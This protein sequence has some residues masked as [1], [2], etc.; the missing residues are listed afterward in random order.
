MTALNTY[1]VEQVIPQKPLANGPELREEDKGPLHGLSPEQVRAKLAKDT[2]AF[3]AKGKVIEQIREGHK[4]VKMH[5][6]PFKLITKAVVPL[7]AG[8]ALVQGDMSDNQDDEIELITD[9]MSQFAGYLNIKVEIISTS[10]KKPCFGEGKA[11]KVAIKGE[12]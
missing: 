11:L 1:E 9:F 5:G 2:E 4:A 8:A 12:K 3:L 7:W 6:K 10:D